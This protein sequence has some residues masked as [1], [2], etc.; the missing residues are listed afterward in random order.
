MA[1]MSFGRLTGGLG[2]PLGQGPH[3]IGHHGEARP[4]LSGPGRLHGGVQGQQVGLEGDL[5]DGLDY[6]L[7]VLTGL[8]DLLHGPHH[9]LHGGPGAVHH[10]G[11]LLEG[12]RLF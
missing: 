2:A 11:G 7:G 5:V 4:R 9:V 10:L 8:G 12:C 1:S 3:L 6:L